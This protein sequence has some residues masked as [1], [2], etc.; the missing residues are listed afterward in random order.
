MNL[1]SMILFEDGRET[2]ALYE[3]T[4][5]LRGTSGMITGKAT[6]SVTSTPDHESHDPLE[7]AFQRLLDIMRGS[8]FG[9]TKIEGDLAIV[10]GEKQ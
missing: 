9:D 1:G 7:A 6:M 4:G 5:A 10:G 2:Q 8:E 3:R